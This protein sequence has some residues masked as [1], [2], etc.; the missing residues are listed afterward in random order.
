MPML[1]WWSW[2][3]DGRGVEAASTASGTDGGGGQASEEN[4]GARGRPK[5]RLDLVQPLLEAAGVEDVE[6][7]R[8]AIERSNRLR[9][10]N[11]KLAGVTEMLDQR[12][13]GLAIE[14]IEE[15]CRDVDID[16]ARVREEAAEAELKVLSEQLEE[17]IVARTE[18]RKA[19]EAI[20]GDDAAA[21]AAADCEEALA[22]MQDAAERYVRVRAS[23]MLL[24]WAVD[25]YRKESRGRC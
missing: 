5:G 8:E 22:A 24:R 18:A 14:V 17:A 12:G 15:E 19:S 23:G 3:V 4:R 7:L 11:E 25:R 13:D 20:G 1:P 10:L 6:E 16:V 2:I 21:R 9:R